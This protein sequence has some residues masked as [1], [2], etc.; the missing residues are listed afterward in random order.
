MRCRR[1]RM[2]SGRLGGD[3]DVEELERAEELLDIVR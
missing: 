1:G 2:R 3:A